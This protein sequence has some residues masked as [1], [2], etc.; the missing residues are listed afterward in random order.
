[1]KGG[2]NRTI[3][4]AG[5]SQQVLQKVVLSEDVKDGEGKK[6]PG[7]NQFEALAAN[8]SMAEGVL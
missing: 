8:R 1:M 2:E 4:S 7:S 6:V 3:P 5:F